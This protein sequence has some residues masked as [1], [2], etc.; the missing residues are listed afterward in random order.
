M[1]TDDRSLMLKLLY[2]FTTIITMILPR[3]TELNTPIKGIVETMYPLKNTTMPLPQSVWGIFLLSSL[4]K[5]Y[6]VALPAWRQETLL[7]K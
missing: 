4:C 2:Y 1:L 5:K 7:F 3:Q 6:C